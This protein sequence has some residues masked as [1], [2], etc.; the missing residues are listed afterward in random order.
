[1]YT[2]AIVSL[3]GRLEYRARDVE[4]VEAEIEGQM[5]RVQTGVHYREVDFKR[6]YALS[7]ALADVICQKVMEGTA[8]TDIPLIPGMPSI[9]ALRRWQKNSP[10]FAERIKEARRYRAEKMRDTAVNLGKD[11][12]GRDKDEIPG[13]KL[14]I[15]SLKWAAEKDDPATYGSKIEVAGNVVVEMRLETG[16]RRI[17]DPGAIIIETAPALPAPIPLSKPEED[18]DK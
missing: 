14:A 13:R 12:V 15:D 1:M 17:N 3:A 11:S 2:G 6:R 8:F 7:D 4:Y 16:I 18:D 10:E 9:G 5:V